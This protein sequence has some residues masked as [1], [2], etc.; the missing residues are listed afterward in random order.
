MGSPSEGNLR[1]DVVAILIRMLA[2][3]LETMP[4]T[5]ISHLTRQLRLPSHGSPQWP[6]SALDRSTLR[7]AHSWS[8]TFQLKRCVLEDAA[9]ALHRPCHGRFHLHPEDGVPAR[10]RAHARST[11]HGFRVRWQRL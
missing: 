2:D 3:A 6:R 1:G 5:K 9:Q 11:G 10:W 7:A 8:P 4:S